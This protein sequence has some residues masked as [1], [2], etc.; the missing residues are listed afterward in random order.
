MR[1]RL[2]SGSIRVVSTGSGEHSS[3]SGEPMDEK[4]FLY[5]GSCVCKDPHSIFRHHF[6]CFL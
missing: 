4:G 3:S 6:T 1:D 2:C 5:N